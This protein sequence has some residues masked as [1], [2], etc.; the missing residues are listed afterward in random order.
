M[1]PYFDYIIDHVPHAITVPH[2]SQF[3]LNKYS[4]FDFLINWNPQNQ[5]CG[6]ATTNKITFETREKT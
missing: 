1:T 6:I 4:K 2:A 5:V 3:R